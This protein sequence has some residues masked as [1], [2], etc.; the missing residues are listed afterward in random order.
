MRDFD[1]QKL[2]EKKIEAPYKPAQA[3]DNFDKAQANNM[4]HWKKDEESAEM[5]QQQMKLLDPVV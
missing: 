4:E 2:L 5:K 1:Y 3:S